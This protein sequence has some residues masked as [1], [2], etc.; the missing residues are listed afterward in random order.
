MKPSFTLLSQVLLAAHIFALVAANTARSQCQRSRT[1]C[2]RRFKAGKV[3][4]LLPTPRRAFTPTL[5]FGKYKLT[6]LRPGVFVYSDGPYQTLMMRAGARA[7]FVDFPDSAASNAPAG[8]GTLLTVA[9]DHLLRGVSPVRID[10]VYSHAHFDHFGKAA[11][12]H[13]HLRRKYPRAE[14]VVWGTADH[15]ELLRVAGRGRAVLPTRL[16]DRKGATIRMARNLVIDLLIVGAHLP[17][18]LAVHVRHSAAGKGVLMYVD[19]VFPNWAPPGNFETTDMRAFIEGHRKLLKL[20]FDAFL[21]GHFFVGT[22]ADVRKN[23]RFTLDTLDAGRKALAAVTLE[24]QVKAGLGLVSDQ[25][26]VQ[27]GNI[28][29][30]VFE[31]SLKLQMEYCYRILFEKWACKL[32]GVDITGR[33]NCQTVIP[34][35]SLRT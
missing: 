31:V 22:K 6:A 18:D 5:P 7:A 15:V 33:Q 3:C 19:L 29:Y 28:Y 20:D 10:M 23:L 9:A 30:G 24:N 16:V 32:A 2:L 8:N 25:K 35:L 1:V 4:D 34:Y 26:A 13:A 21:P 12:F 17:Q 14:I 11:V 27:F